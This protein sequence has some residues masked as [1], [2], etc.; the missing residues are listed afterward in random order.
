MSGGQTAQIENGFFSGTQPE[1]VTN[2]AGGII[3]VSGIGSSLSINSSAFDNS[4]VVEA[5]NGGFL[6]IEDPVNNSGT[7]VLAAN[8]ATIIVAGAVTGDGTSTIS[9][10]GLLDFQSS[11]SADQAVD[12]TG[13]GTLDFATAPASGLAIADWR[14]RHHRPRQPRILGG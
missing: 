8:G 7:G 14:K 5:T 10:S 13:A 2:Q 4:G 11:V 9:N 1:G 3:S 6:Q 12:F